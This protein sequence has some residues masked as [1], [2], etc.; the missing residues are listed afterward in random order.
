[1]SQRD[2]QSAA[3]SAPPRALSTTTSQGGVCH[4]NSSRRATAVRAKSAALS[5]RI[6]MWTRSGSN[7]ACEERGEVR[8]TSHISRLSNFRYRE[9]VLDGAV[10]PAPF[11]RGAIA[12]RDRGHR[13]CRAAHLGAGV[14]DRKA[15]GAG[16]PAAGGRVSL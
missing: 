16:S 4:T 10:S 15:T 6:F 13:R 3:I 1:N 14:S 2:N 9:P 11:L 5:W 12:P 7:H 8:L